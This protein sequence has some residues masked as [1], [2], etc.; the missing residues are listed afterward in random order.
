MNAWWVFAWIVVPALAQEIHVEPTQ[1]PQGGV[2]RIT[3][4][5][6]SATMDGRTVRVF[7]QAGG[8]TLG[9]MPVTAIQTP[10]PYPLELLDNA[11]KVIRTVQIAVRD[12]HFPKQ[13]IAMSPHIAQ[14]RPAPGEM[15]AAGAF[16]KTVTDVRYWHQPFDK[17]VPGCMGSPYGVTRLHNGKLTGAFHGGLDQRA[18]AGEPVRAIAAGTVRL[19]R[20]F[21]LMGNTVGIDHGQGVLS[22]YLHLS[23]FAVADGAAVNKG[24]VVGYV[25]ATGRATGPHLHWSL[26]IN[27]VPVNPLEWITVKPCAPA[28]RRVKP[29]RK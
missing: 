2:I 9:M 26:Y 5:A 13:N 18:P 19:V 7:P 27:G 25:G 15:E 10:G 1:V 20:P 29:R 12:A 24:D 6:A 14:L 28:A 16:R 3:G 4:N 8:G 23:K 21:Q 22:M 17:P 11:G